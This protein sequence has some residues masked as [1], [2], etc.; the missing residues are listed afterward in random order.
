MLRE[1]LVDDLVVDA[2]VQ[3]HDT[4]AETEHLSEAG[5]AASGEVT[6]GLEALEQVAAG[7]GGAEAEAGDDMAP[8]S[9]RIWIAT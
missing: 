8:T 6:R 1:D 7:R 9:I 2:V 3:M 5:G 4:V